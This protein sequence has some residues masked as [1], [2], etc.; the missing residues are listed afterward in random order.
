MRHLIMS[1]GKISAFL[2]SH[3]PTLA[4]TKYPVTLL[5]TRVETINSQRG[6]VQALEY[7]VDLSPHQRVMV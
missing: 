6:R 1:Y 2:L 3:V 5:N 7:K 4:T